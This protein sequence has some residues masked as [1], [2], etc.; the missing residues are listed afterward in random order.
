M[1]TEQS[2]PMHPE[3][4]V[5]PKVTFALFG[6]NQENYIREAVQ[7]AFSQD[8]SPLEIILSDDCSKD[9]TFGIMEEM[10]AGYEGPHQVILNRN[11]TNVGLIEHINRVMAMASGSWIVMA[12][13]DD[14]SLSG[15]V[16]TTMRLAAEN[17]RARSIFVGYD[18]IGG[19]PDFRA[20]PPH[21]AGIRRFPMNLSTHGA[22]GLGA[23]QGFDREVWRRFGPL[24]KGL[25]REDAILPFRA[26]LLGDVLVDEAVEVHYRISV[27]SLSTGYQKRPSY[28]AMVRTR[29]GE[30][31]EIREIERTLTE[32]V[33]EGL[34]G[35]ADYESCRATVSKMAR[36]AA[37]SV[38]TL[39]GS[40]LKRVQ[41]AV[42]VVL[43][44]P[45]YSELCGN[46]KFRLA[47]ARQAIRL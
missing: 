46:Y 23:C 33:K 6:Y 22:C 17:P 11:D 12:A 21:H 4:G 9:G 47:I 39:D 40:R 25:H 5:A 29:K 35:E 34:I 37:A 10:A 18:A 14:I 1:A 2:A 13:G 42:R 28:K 31:E 8:Y 30:L 16:S 19:I 27:D 32:A 26:S 41:E 44:M 20:L 3:R 24:P 36:T 43:C 15:R 38:G 7:G 45:P